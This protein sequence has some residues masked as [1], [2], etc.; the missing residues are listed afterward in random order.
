MATIRDQ[1]PKYNELLQALNPHGDLGISVS[2][3]RS[4]VGHL[5]NGEDNAGLSR[6][7]LAEFL[8]S[9]LDKQLKILKIVNAAQEDA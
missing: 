6:E 9:M 3:L 2:N 1:N 4:I 7:A 8:A 5:L